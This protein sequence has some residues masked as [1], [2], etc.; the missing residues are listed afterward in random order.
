MLNIVAGRSGTGKTTGARTVFKEYRE[1]GKDFSK[2]VGFMMVEKNRLPFRDGGK[3]MLIKD[4]NYDLI[5]KVL[6]NPT[7]NCYIIDDSQFLMAHELFN[8]CHENGYGKFTDMAK[9]FYDLLNWI[10]HNVPEDVNVY[11]LHHT[12]MG[13]DGNLKLKTCGKMLDEKYPIEGV[14]NIILQTE[15][16]QNG[17]HFRT[18]TRGNDVV[19]TPLGMFED[20]LIPNDIMLVDKTIREYYGLKPITDHPAPK[21]PTPPAPNQGKVTTTNT[22]PPTSKPAEKK[23]A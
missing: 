9:H 12:E 14:V 18:K 11:F 23:P 7:L 13:D 22:V 19:K 16:D 5:M 3:A 8:R 10:N 2:D 4:A 15:V 20:E 6:R 21:Q 1:D 17:F